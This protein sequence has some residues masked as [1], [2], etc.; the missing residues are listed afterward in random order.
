[1]IKKLIITD[2][3]GLKEHFRIEY[4]K[5]WQCK[6]K[7]HGFNLDKDDA[8]I[9]ESHGVPN[10]VF[11]M[12]NNR[13]AARSKFIA[14]IADNGIMYVLQILDPDNVCTDNKLDENIENNKSSINYNNIEIRLY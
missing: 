9:F 5:I 14:P 1:M 13:D 7:H 4:M 2:G 6:F 8:T 12:H 3:K 10:A 11:Q